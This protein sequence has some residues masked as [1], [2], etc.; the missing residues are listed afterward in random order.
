MC[1]SMPSPYDA[2]GKQTTRRK[3]G[4]HNSRPQPQEC[5]PFNVHCANAH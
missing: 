4:R 5:A 1:E 3:K 2:K